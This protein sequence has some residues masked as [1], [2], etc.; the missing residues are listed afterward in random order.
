[1][2]THNFFLLQEVVDNAFKKKTLIDHDSISA[3]FQSKLQE[4][5]S[6]DQLADLLIYSGF[7][8]HLLHVRA[9]LMAQLVKKLPAM[10]ETPV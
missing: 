5:F 10:Q 8:L 6:D 3:N 1:M 2:E 4:D 9:S 7:I